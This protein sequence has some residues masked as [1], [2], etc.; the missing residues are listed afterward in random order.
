MKGKCKVLVEQT[1]VYDVEFIGSQV[2]VVDLYFTSPA[3]DYTTGYASLPREAKAAI[4]RQVVAD[5]QDKDR[6]LQSNYAGDPFG[7]VK[8]L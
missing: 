1:L 8:P 6:E 5:A 7:G 2:N 3:G 4:L